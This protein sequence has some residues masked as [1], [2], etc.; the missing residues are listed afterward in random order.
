MHTPMA[1]RMII[2]FSLFLWTGGYLHSER[3]LAH[4]VESFEK[5]QIDSI[6]FSLSQNEREDLLSQLPTDADL[7]DPSLVLVNESH[8]WNHD[9]VVDLVEIQTGFLADRHAK[10][11]FVDLWQA[12]KRAGHYLTVVSAH[13]TKEQQAANRQQRIKWYQSLGYSLPQSI[14]L[15]N[16]Y[17]AKPESTEHLTGLALD[18]IGDDWL[19]NRNDLS[20]DYSSYESAKWLA[21]NAHN[22]G[23]ILRYPEGKKRETGYQFEPWHYRYVGR[24]NAAFIH[25]YQ[26]TL[27]EYIDLL[28]ERKMQIEQ[29]DHQPIPAK[30]SD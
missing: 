27:E 6:S 18:L 12:G 30:D 3:I 7:N 13:R 2:L 10:Q 15:T 29:I 19:R 14:D 20:Q 23:F 17:Y 25:K 5:L 11:A 22:F 21:E 4:H 26:L 9:R 1:K 8:P 16:S 28:Q 24:S